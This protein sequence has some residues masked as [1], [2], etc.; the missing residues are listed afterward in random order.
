MIAIALAVPTKLENRGEDAEGRNAFSMHAA[1]NDLI[2][3]TRHV[4]C[5]QELARQSDPTDWGIDRIPGTDQASSRTRVS[6]DKRRVGVVGRIVCRSSGKAGNCSLSWQMQVRMP[7]ALDSARDWRGQRTRL[8]QPGRARRDRRARQDPWTCNLRGNH[9]TEQ[10]QSGTC[11]AVRAVPRA[12]VPRT[13]GDHPCSRAKL[14][15]IS[16][17]A[18]GPADRLRP[19]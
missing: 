3:E 14:I 17:A 11:I 5:E 16:A 13:R 2:D 8:R 1:R 18:A 10:A 7:P 12:A 15:M 19:N 6:S 4:V 9:T